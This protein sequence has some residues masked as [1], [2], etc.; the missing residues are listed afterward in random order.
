[1]CCDQEE[2]TLKLLKSLLLKI[3]QRTI[4]AILYYEAFAGE[5]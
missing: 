2:L 5:I 1:M 3:L 4:S